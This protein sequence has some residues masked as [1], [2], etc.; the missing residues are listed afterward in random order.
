M[1]RFN[2]QTVPHGMKKLFVAKLED[3]PNEGKSMDDGKN[4]SPDAFIKLR[5]QEKNDP[6]EKPKYGM[7]R[8]HQPGPGGAL[9][10]RGFKKRAKK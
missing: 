4:K 10:H 8:N 1:S 7:Q 9:G 3:D 5:E 6:A 2:I